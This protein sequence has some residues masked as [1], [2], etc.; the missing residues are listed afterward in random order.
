[1]PRREDAGHVAAIVSFGLALAATAVLAAAPLGSRQEAVLNS[2]NDESSGRVERVSLLEH[3]GPSV[4]L[5]LA[6]PAVIAAL[7]VVASHSPARKAV[8]ATSAG[9]LVAFVFLGLMSIGVF[10]LPSAVAM[11]VATAKTRPSYSTPL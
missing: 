8:R 4:L 3:E 5:L 10:Y 6:V 7:G 11:M 9:L 1:M 2:P